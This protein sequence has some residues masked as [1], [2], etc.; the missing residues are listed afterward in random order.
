[1]P[2]VKARSP[3]PQLEVETLGGSTWRLADQ[4]GW[5]MIEFYRGLHCPGCQAYLR[6]MDRHVDEFRGIG[7]EMIAISGDSRERA[8]R[9]RDEW[10]LEKLTIGYG[11]D[12]ET[13]EAWDL[14]ISKGLSDDEPEVSSEPGLYVVRRDGSIYYAAV[15]SMT[16]GRPRMS[17]LLKALQ[18]KIEQ[19]APARGEV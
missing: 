6:D 7:V 13:M 1:L 19:D 18:I 11:L 12:V 5:T 16:F 15:N 17:E 10:G 14:Y 2:R 9:A 8:Q 4:E 3:A